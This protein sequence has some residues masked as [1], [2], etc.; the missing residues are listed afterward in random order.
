MNLFA[1]LLVNVLFDHFIGNVARGNR[2]VAPRPKVTSPEDFSQVGKFGEDF[3]RTLALDALGNRA[4]GCARWVG[5]K[6]MYMVRGYLAGDNFNILSRTNFA[7]HI[8]DL[9]P[10]HADQHTLSI[11]GDEDDMDLQVILRVGA[12]TIESHNKSTL[13]APPGSF[14][15]K[16]SPKGEGFHPS[17]RGT[18]NT[19]KAN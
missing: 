14:K 12:G 7:D 10:D 13:L 18:L 11:F 2:K 5:D 19:R 17:P 15:L 8:T 3:V 6:E 16:P 4:D 1:F 9:Q